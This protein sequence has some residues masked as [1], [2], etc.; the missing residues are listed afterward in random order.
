M[1]IFEHVHK[2]TKMN[3]AKSCN[4]TTNC[5]YE[6]SMILTSVISYEK[7]S[8]RT[9]TDIYITFDFFMKMMEEMNFKH[10]KFF[11]L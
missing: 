1:P 4:Y 9:Q 11:N 3:D 2:N 10:Y 5:A 6:K 8:N 7:L